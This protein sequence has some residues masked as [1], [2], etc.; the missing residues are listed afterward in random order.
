[1]KLSDNEKRQLVLVA[2]EAILH[3]LSCHHRRQVN[4]ADYALAFQTKAASFV[5]LTIMGNLR[6]CVGS[7][8]TYRSLIE[9][10]AHNA[11]SAA[12][13]DSRFQP[14][15]PD[16]YPALEVRTSVLSPKEAILFSSGE[17]L[18][19]QIRPSIDGLL[20]EKNERHATFL[21]SVWASFPD[22]PEFLDQLK[23]KAQIDD[24]DPGVLKVWRYT[25]VSFS[26]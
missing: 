25:T 15:S 20:I 22:P 21:P 24:G 1:M 2:R 19:R 9:D 10:V 5:T 17:D 14:L 13:E 11:Y 23:R 18:L 16:E 26:D 8:E 12:F 6:G 7:T 4:A 3:G